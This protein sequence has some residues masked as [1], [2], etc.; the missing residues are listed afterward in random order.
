MFLAL[1]LGTVFFVLAVWYKRDL[2]PL[3]AS[4]NSPDQ[5]MAGSIL[6]ALKRHESITPLSLWLTIEKHPQ[7]LFITNHFLIHT[8]T[9]S[10]A[11]QQPTMDTAQVLKQSNH[12]AELTQSPTIQPVHLA[13]ALISSSKE[14]ND[15]FT[16]MKLKPDDLESVILWLG[17]FIKR[18]ALDK[19][20]FGGI[21]RDWAN[22]FTPRLNRF[23]HNI[24]LAIERGNQNY[25][26]LT[27]SPEVTALKNA[28]SQGASAVAL[29]GPQGIGKTSCVHALAQLLLAER[30]DRNLEHRQIVSLSPSF[31]LSS[32]R[33]PGQ[34]ENIVLA[35]MEETVH[36]GHIILFMDDAQLFFGNG[37]GSFDISQI[38]Q[39]IIQSRAI[40]IVL[41]LTPSDFQR[42]KIQNAAFANLLTPINLVEP[43]QASIMAVLED[44]AIVFENQHDVLISYEALKEAYRLS[45]RYVQELAYPGR[46]IQLLEQSIAHAEQGIVSQDSVQQATEQAYGVKV[47]SVVPQETDSL[48]HL[49]DNIHKRMINQKRA[50]NVVANALRRSRA[51]VANPRRPIG[52]FLFLGP[53]GVGKTEL[54]KAI[55]GVYFDDE[56]SMI[57]LDMSEYQQPEDVSRLLSAGSTEAA[58][59]LMSVRQKPSSVVLLDEIEKAHPNILNLLLQLLDEGQLTDT[60]GRM[61]SFKDNIIIATS[62]AGAQM[63]RERI[64][65]GEDLE[66][67][68]SAFIDDLMKG[69]QFK[70]ELLNRFDEIVLFRPLNAEELLQVVALMMAEV[71][72]T[73]SNQNITISLTEAAARQIVAKGYDAR[74]GARPMRRM[75]QRM[76][77]DEVANRIIR[78]DIQSGD[79]VTFDE[80]DLIL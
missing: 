45:G 72:A 37:P 52:S 19:P 50:V 54:A 25:G 62:N 33:Q 34:I 36:A 63:I 71:N 35:L 8:D 42:L 21:G 22:G 39:P 14:M 66:Q 3:Q 80:T 79:C 10:A 20:Y 11:L 26:S 68:E 44:S 9:V 57:R 32:A 31:I 46:A 29:I 12:F 59:L 58:S 76:V 13:G 27:S 15:L 47:R 67:F 43:D 30:N 60:N 65:L 6:G 7:V 28:F 64:A 61:A 17:R 49:E 41:A 1:S 53:T 56:S 23:G 55:A 16:R 18:S 74:L 77:E 38:L 73:L 40:Q 48:I 5:K 69:S 24:S 78:G 75:L 70:P 2:A 51:G 4:G